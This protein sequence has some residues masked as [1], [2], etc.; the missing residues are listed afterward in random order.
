MQMLAPTSGAGS[1]ILAEAE[2]ASHEESPP[3][4]TNSQEAGGQHSSS[5]VDQQI[6]S[7]EGEDDDMDLDMDHPDESTVD[8]GPDQEL[9]DEIEE[10]EIGPRKRAKFEKTLTTQSTERPSEVSLASDS[11]SS[12]MPEETSKTGGV[13]VSS[14][15]TMQKYIRATHGLQLQEF[16]LYLIP[17]RASIVARALDLSVLKRITLLEVGSQVAFW[18]LLQ[19]LSKSVPDL[20]FHMIHTDD[21]SMAFLNFL[22]TSDGVRELYLHKKKKKEP[23]PET[24]AP[25]VDIK[26]ICKLGLRKHFD[27]ITHLMLKNDIDETW[28]LDHWIVR[29]FSLRGSGLVELA[30][31]MKLQTLVSTS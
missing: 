10:P 29:T 22:S 1:N 7:T 24:T 20:G 27:T 23:E 4:F 30:V 14:D 19:R 26:A 3:S 12:K 21:V 5:I 13:E 6:L 9:V 18:Q 31:S 17:L 25:K 11:L 28:D 8:V 16:S 15:N 2:P